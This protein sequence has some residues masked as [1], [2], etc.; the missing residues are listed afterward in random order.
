VSIPQVIID[1]NVLIAALYSR[2]GY[3]FALISRLGDAPFE[4]NISVSLVLEYEGIGKRM[5]DRLQIS[6][7]ELEAVI[8]Y[9]CEIGNQQKIFYLWRP[10]LKDPGDDMVLELAVAARCEYI[11]T[12]NKKDFSGVEEQFGIAIVTPAEFLRRMGV[13]K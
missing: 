9:L 6:E 12:F 13:E 8:D 4:I 5:L 2:L 10:F 1:T 11:V 3:A 7:D